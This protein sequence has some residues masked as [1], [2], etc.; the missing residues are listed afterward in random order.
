M[1]R[2]I[3][4]RAFDLKFRKI[5]PVKFI[6]FIMGLVSYILE[7]GEMIHFIPIDKDCILMQ[8][9]GLLDKNGKEIYEGDIV[10]TKFWNKDKG[11][12]IENEFIGVIEYWGESYASFHILDKNGGGIPLEWACHKSDGWHIYGEIVSNIYENPKLLTK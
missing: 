1:T 3:K 7:N 11:I 10:K 2:E 4:F 5:Y 9:T 8:F 6:E 12:F